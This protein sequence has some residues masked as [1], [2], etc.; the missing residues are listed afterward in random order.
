[1][2][3]SLYLPS[4]SLRCTLCNARS[5]RCTLS[6]NISDSHFVVIVISSP[7]FNSDLHNLRLIYRRNNK[8][9]SLFQSPSYLISLK[10][11]RCNYRFQLSS[12]KTSYFI[13]LLSDLNPNS[14]RLSTCL[15][16][17]LKNIK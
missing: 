4:N 14:K 13:Y 12:A 17:F 9:F 16:P 10:I 5:V 1:M 6:H 15:F 11:F 7:W 8:H 3:S 2:T